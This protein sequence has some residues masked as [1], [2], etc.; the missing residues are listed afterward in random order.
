MQNQSIQQLEEY[1]IDGNNFHEETEVTIRSNEGD[2]R[3]VDARNSLDFRQDKNKRQDTTHYRHETRYSVGDTRNTSK[4][5]D[6]VIKKPTKI[7]AQVQIISEKG[8]D[9]S[10][11]NQNLLAV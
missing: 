8:K 7:D 10:V 6:V 5:L 11:D 9:L 2:D 4:D 3:R 1:A